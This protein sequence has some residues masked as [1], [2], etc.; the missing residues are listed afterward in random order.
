ML[1]LLAVIASDRLTITITSASTDKH[2]V[3]KAAMTI[4]IIASL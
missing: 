2:Q 3:T 1:A 4:T